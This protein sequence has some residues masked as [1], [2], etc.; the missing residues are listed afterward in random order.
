MTS[1]I[2]ACFLFLPMSTQLASYE[3]ICPLS[4]YNIK[5]A[6]DLMKTTQELI[7]E[8]GK[9]GLDTSEAEQVLTEAMIILERART[10]S[11]QG[12]NCIAGN[13]VAIKCQTLLKR[14]QEM[15]ESMLDALRVEEYTVYSVLIKATYTEGLMFSEDVYISGKVKIIVVMDH[16]SLDESA[17]DGIDK[18]LRWVHENMSG[19]DKETLDNFRT[20]NVQKRP[21]YDLFDLSVDVVFMSEEEVEKHFQSSGWIEFYEKYP[22]S[23]GIMTLSGVGFNSEMNQALVY[24]G[25]RSSWDSGAGYYVLLIKENGVWIIQDDIILWIS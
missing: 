4:R 25:N 19:L 1:L 16:T 10:V 13:M 22:F 17:E 6:E 20:R 18:T 24:V 8:A 15:L 5:V 9:Q 14:S 23:Q 7:E 3:Q 2:L 12:Q 11:E 21:L